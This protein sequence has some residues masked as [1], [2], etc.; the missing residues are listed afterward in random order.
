MNRLITPSP[1]KQQRT[2][3]LYPRQKGVG[4][5][6]VLVALV[7]LSLGFLVSANMQLRGMRSNQ[8]SYH[9]SQ[10]LM[11]ANDMMDRM[12]NNRPGVIAGAYDG[13]ETDVV[14]VPGCASAG[15]DSAGLALLDRY[16]W[17][18][19]LNNLDNDAAYIP[20]LPAARDQ[21]PAKGTISQPDTDGAY[22]LTMSWTRQS[23][24]GESEESL[25]VR[26]LP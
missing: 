14:T 7:V 20:M 22:A 5:I 3:A 25:T 1:L 4:L 2:A 12:R 13:M 16:E 17:S 18:A 8:D 24:E 21:S 11:L 19:Q 26:F 10:A 6:E 15:C 23:R 9:E